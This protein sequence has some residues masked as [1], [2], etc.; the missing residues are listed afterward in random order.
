M[1]LGSVQRATKPMAKRLHSATVVEIHGRMVL[2]TS[3][4]A[5]P[6]TQQIVDGH[7]DLG[8]T[9]NSNLPNTEQIR[10]ALRAAPDQVARLSPKLL[11][12]PDDPEIQRAIRPRQDVGKVAKAVGRP[13]VPVCRHCLLLRR[14]HR[15]LLWTIQPCKHIC[16]QLDLHQQGMSL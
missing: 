10:Q 3:S 13:R 6:Q 15:G 7:T 9:G 14:P 2:H 12:G 8:R 4:T 11:P 1:D 5:K 16:R